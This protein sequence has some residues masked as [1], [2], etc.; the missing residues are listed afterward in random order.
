[1]RSDRSKGPGLLFVLGVI[2][3]T[4]TLLAADS[5]RVTPLV[6]DGRVL[7]SFQL[8]NG[9]TE[10]VRAAIYSGLRTTFTYTVELRVESAIWVDRMIASVIVDNTVEYDN[11]ARRHSLSRIVDGRLEDARITEDESL[12]RQWMTTLDRLPVFR[13]SKL[14]P[15]REYYVRVV[16]R[17]RP[18]TDAF[19]WP[20]ASGL[21]GQK[22]FTFIR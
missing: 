13:T 22:K 5:I 4:A 16:A 11:L 12:V 15:N 19:F 8:D 2:A 9:F 1:M 3:S 17:A 18:R 7:V 14:E 21:S 6:R 20:F 10:D